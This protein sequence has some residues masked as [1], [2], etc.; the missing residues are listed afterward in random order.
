[1]E[2]V[3]SNRFS[4][5]KTETII[6]DN[7]KTFGAGIILV[8]L[9]NGE[10]E[11]GESYFGGRRKGERG[12]G[13]AEKVPVFGILEREGIVRVEVIPNVTTS[14]LVNS[15]LKKVRR[16]RIVY[17]D[18]L[19]GYDSLMFCGYQQLNGSVDHGSVSDQVNTLI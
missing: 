4:W 19:R 7:C 13:A 11:A 6:L 17:T 2:T 14:T 10:I 12:C 15:T 8:S 18:K 16:G 1:V 3:F 9:L 5:V